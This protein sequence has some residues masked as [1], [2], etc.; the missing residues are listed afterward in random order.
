MRTARITRQAVRGV[1]AATLLPTA[2]LLLT[3]MPLEDLLK[4]LSSILF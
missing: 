3:V 4:K 2:P 1:A